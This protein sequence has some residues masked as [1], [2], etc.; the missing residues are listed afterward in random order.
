MATGATLKFVTP[1]LAQAADEPVFRMAMQIVSAHL[2]TFR[3]N[4]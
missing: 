3:S 4:S 1:L 2:A